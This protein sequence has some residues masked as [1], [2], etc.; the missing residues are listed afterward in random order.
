MNIL[1]IAEHNEDK[2]NGSTLS[3]I[4]AAANLS[5]KKISLLIMGLNCSKLIA[6]AIK[7]ADVSEIIV[8][9][10]PA[11]KN[12]TTEN[13]AELIADEGKKYDYII[14]G[15]SNFS[16]SIMPR[17]SAL[18][19]M[20]MI[21]E[22]NGIINDNTFI[23]PIYA[24]NA[25]ATVECLE[26][27]KIITVR[28]SSFSQECSITTENNVLITKLTSIKENHLSKFIEK[29]EN[30]NER[31]ELSTAKIVVAGGKSLENL[32]NFNSI[33]G[34]LADKL[35]AATGATRDAVNTGLAPN[36]L[37]IGQSGKSI[38]PDLYIAIGISG[39]SQHVSGI[40]DS[41]VIVAINKD[42]EAP[43]F[44]IAD[45]GIVDDLFTSVPKL[46]K[47]L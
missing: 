8:A 45:Y 11:F 4:N 33:I 46:I 12:I 47:L 40:K 9:D 22:I 38:S 29:K 43:I 5:N 28:T 15:A 35:G 6:T 44:E 25:V 32:E 27:I 10:F 17:V 23:R 30:K 7:I 34:G 21:S 19:D 26:K 2:I 31:P 3:A 18:L 1:I 36:D 42:P 39:A 14:A 16:R 20:Q 37:Q 41:K 13:A 24:G